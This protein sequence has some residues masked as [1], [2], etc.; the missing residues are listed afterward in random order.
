M[1]VTVSARSDDGVIEAVELD[2]VPFGI[3]V[4]WHPEQSQDD[5]RLFEGLV[6]AAKK[7]RNK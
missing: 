2:S 3:A 5:L 1:N 6:E 4:Q 7:Y